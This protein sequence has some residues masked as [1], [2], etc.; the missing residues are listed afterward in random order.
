MSVPFGEVLKRMRKDAGLTQVQ[1]AAAVGVGQNTVSEW[2]A[3]A[4]EPRWSEV[5]RLA[6]AL[7]VTPDA[8]LSPETEPAA[9]PPRPIGKRK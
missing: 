8:F 1:L 7:G 2:E 5:V 6:A 4:Y 9:E 3:S